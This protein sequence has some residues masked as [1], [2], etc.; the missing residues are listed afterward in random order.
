MSSRHPLV[1]LPPREPAEQ[2]GA[3][4]QHGAQLRVERTLADQPQ[5]RVGN[6]APD[7]AERLERV[8]RALVRR[9]PADEQER[10][11]RL[12][13]RQL[14]IRRRLVPAVGDDGDALESQ[15]HEVVASRRR[16]GDDRG[17]AV[18]PEKPEL[19]PPPHAGERPW[20][21]RVPDVDRQLVEQGHGGGKP[22][23]PEGRQERNRVHALDH[24]VEAAEASELALDAQ[25]ERARTEAAEPPD[26]HAVDPRGRGGA[27]ETRGELGHV[28]ALR[29][30][31]LRHLVGH[32]LGPACLRVLDVAPVDEADPRAITPPAARATEPPARAPGQACATIRVQNVVAVEDRERVADDAQ[33]G[34]GVDVAREAIVDPDGRLEHAGEAEAAR[35][36]EELEIEGVALLEHPRQH[37]GEDV[38]ADQLQAGL[39]VAHVHPEEQSRE[40]VV[41]PAQQSAQGRVV[42]VRERVALGAED[43]V[44]VVQPHQREE[45]RERLRGDVTVGVAEGDVLAARLSETHAERVA[46]ALAERVFDDPDRLG[47]ERA[48]GR[49]RLVGAAV[50]DDD[51]LVG[52]DPVQLPEK[53]LDHRAQRRARVVARQD[54]RDVERARL[55]ERS[56]RSGRPAGRSAAASGRSRLPPRIR[57]TRRPPPRSRSPPRPARPSRG[58]R[59]SPPPRRPRRPGRS[60][61]RATPSRCGSR[62]GR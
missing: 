7:R 37:R 32:D 27:R 11:R 34:S 21:L 20:Q 54:D 46:F 18:E 24:H 59:R 5:P 39:R 1:Q 47:L 61:T 40:L 53:P 55:G 19:E 43:D 48:R 26:V 38:A 15:L 28:V 4:G 50:G 49:H 62:R 16:H 29:R 30:P 52:A 44:G 57:G 12:L 9:Q 56:H 17:L 25:M 14:E 33:R 8:L 51:E 2:L 10:R 60:G 6:R 42:D 22:A 3:R 45:G 36:D 41:R 35:D 58:R 13:R 23:A 31:A